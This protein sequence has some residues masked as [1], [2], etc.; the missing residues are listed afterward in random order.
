MRIAGLES[1]PVVCR[2]PS[3]SAVPKATVQSKPILQGKIREVRKRRGPPCLQAAGAI[4]EKEQML[5]STPDTLL[6]E[7]SAE[8]DGIRG[9]FERRIREAQNEICAAVEAEDG[10]GKFRE[11]A[12]CRPG[13][14]GGVSRVMQGGKVWEKAGVG[15]SVVYGTMP[16]EAYRA[17]K[18]NNNNSKP[19]TN[20]ASGGVPFF[21]AGIS[22]VMHPHNPFAPTMH[23]NYRYFE[24][25]EWNGI[26]G[27]WWFGGGTD[28]TP[29]YLNEEDMRHFHGTYKRVC[30]K[31]DPA[32][33]PRFKQWADE[34]FYCKHRD[35]RRG[36]GGIFFDD[37]ND[38]PQDEIMAFSSE[39]L[40]SV[41]DSYLPLVQKHK[42][43]EF[44]AKQKE[45]QQMR[46]GLY[47]EY[48]L[49]YDRG[50]TFGLK[51]AGRIESILMSLPLTARWEYCPPVDPN[52]PE[53][54]LVDACRNP[55]TWV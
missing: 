43:D 48:N 30:D 49:V 18:G 41:V 54:Q 31:H 42:N 21:A 37:L 35:Q 52:S 8:G 23:F 47:V 13:G 12:W 55:R 45:W 11:D 14:G 22:S 50:T 39:A 38:R 44:T 24:T 29:S 6:R 16:P 3:S 51:T 4:I 17:A 10:E 20:G 36:L 26:P 34:Y 25:E 19:T 40:G 28:I 2:C 32:Y 27:Q 5:D 1:K 9:R 7:E 53:A 46:R 15:V 33:Y